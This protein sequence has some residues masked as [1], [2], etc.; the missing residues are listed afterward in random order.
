LPSSGLSER[1]VQP[2]NE[3]V[4]SD[5]LQEVSD[6]IMTEYEVVDHDRFL[7]QIDVGGLPYDCAFCA[8]PLAEYGAVLAFGRLI[9]KRPWFADQN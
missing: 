8:S 6:K 3:Y 2:D 9:A 5:A 1:A 4:D 7:A